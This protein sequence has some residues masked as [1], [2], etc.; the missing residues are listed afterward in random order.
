M[1]LIWTRRTNEWYEYTEINAFDN[2]IDSYFCFLWQFPRY[3]RGVRHIDLKSAQVGFR[4]ADGAL[5]TQYVKI[6]LKSQPGHGINSKLF[7]YTNY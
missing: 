6:H 5:G 1:F 2:N 3:V 7:F 4:I